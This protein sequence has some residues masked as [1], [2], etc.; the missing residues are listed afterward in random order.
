MYQIIKLQFK[1]NQI[2]FITLA[3]LG[4]LLSFNFIGSIQMSSEF[5]II[6]PILY[7]SFFN[8]FQNSRRN[9]HILQLSLPIEKKIIVRGIMLSD[10][11]CVLFVT[12]LNIGCIYIS[13][14][15]LNSGY[16][17]NQ[18]LS[19][20]LYILL[21]LFIFIPF[22]ETLLLSLGANKGIILSTL[23]ICVIFILCLV[24]VGLLAREGFLLNFAVDHMFLLMAIT[25]LIGFISPL[26]FQSIATKFYIKKE[27]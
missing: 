23:L 16:S 3:F 26:L 2:F 22:V 1:I 15:L 6:Y 27:Y 25:I 12:T 24:F 14:L 13:N 17:M 19:F 10:I 21:I 20:Y 8:V 18:Y 11:L 7:I 9:K 4:I 5:F